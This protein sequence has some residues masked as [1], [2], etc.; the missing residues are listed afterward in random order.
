MKENPLEP[1]IVICVPS[2]HERKE[3]CSYFT[4]RQNGI[5]FQSGRYRGERTRKS[6]FIFRAYGQ[7]V[8]EGLC[9]GHFTEVW[10]KRKKKADQQNTESKPE[11]SPKSTVVVPYIA[12]ISGQIC[13]VLKQV[14][15]RAVNKAQPWQWQVCKEIKD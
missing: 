14:G 11:E 13:R 15:I 10:G 8:P 5:I 7:W 6:I 2:S 3:R 1:S 9:S 4:V 12:G